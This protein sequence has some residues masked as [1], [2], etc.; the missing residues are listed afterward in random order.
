[1]LW[2]QIL[3]TPGRLYIS[4]DIYIYIYTV[5][6]YIHII[7]VCT[8]TMEISV[9]TPNICRTRAPHKNRSLQCFE[10]HIFCWIFR[11]SNHPIEEGGNDVNGNHLQGLRRSKANQ[12]PWRS[13][14][15]SFRRCESWVLQH[16]N[17]QTFTILYPIFTWLSVISQHFPICV[18]VLH[19]LWPGFTEPKILDSSVKR[20]QWQGTTHPGST[21]QLWGAPKSQLHT[22]IST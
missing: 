14:T 3:S 9:N 11:A 10:R 4:R 1:M 21:W 16:R 18:G 15:R 20:Q 13:P 19:G 22:N 7:C 17:S 5:Y 12:N 2:N 8:C 6:I